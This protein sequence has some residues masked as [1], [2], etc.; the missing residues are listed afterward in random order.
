MRG[1]CAAAMVFMCVVVLLGGTGC[2]L[3]D[4]TLR[5]VN[6]SDDLVT[7]LRVVYTG[8]PVWSGNWL[9]EDLTPGASRAFGD[10]ETARLDV[11]I[12]VDRPAPDDQY[13]FDNVLFSGGRTFVFTVT[14][15]D[16]ALTV[17]PRPIPVKAG[18]EL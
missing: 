16:A 11:L 17:I 8:D 1:L 12:V 9:P 2:P 15:D 14:N 7:E 18:G 3:R 4:N 5:I 6:E 13:E 10:I